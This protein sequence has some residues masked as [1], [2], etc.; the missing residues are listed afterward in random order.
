M[1]DN[2]LLIVYTLLQV[3]MSR[4]FPNGLGDL[5]RGQDLMTG[6]WLMS[7]LDKRMKRE[8]L[9]AWDAHNYEQA[10]CNLTLS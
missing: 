4:H 1:W 3:L 10:L 8:H 7:R 9:Y 2:Y 5:Q 6:L